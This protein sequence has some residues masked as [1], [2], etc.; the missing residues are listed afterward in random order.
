MT[1]LL[2]N[3]YVCTGENDGFVADG[4][5]LIRETKIVW[6]GRLA[7]LPAQS[8]AVEKRDMGGRIIIPGLVNTHAHGGMSAHR[9]CCDEGNLFEW[10]QALAPHTSI[11]TLED[12]RYGCQLA[13]MEMVRNGITTACDCTRYGAG[14]FASVATSIGMRSLSGALANSPSLR[15]AG[16]PN[17]PLALE[18]TQAALVE[19]A[20]NGLARFYLGAHSPYSCTPELLV[21][22][23]Q[24]ANPL[25]LP[26]VIHVAESAIEVEM[27]R[28]RHGTT[29]FRHLYQLGVIDDRSILAHCVW[30]DD[31]EI[32]LL[33]ESGAGVAHNPISNAKL[34]SGIAPVPAMRRAGIPVGLGTDSTVSNNS[35]D[36]FQEMKFSVLLQRASTLDAH[37]SGAP[38]AFAMA[39]SE[40]ARVLGWADQ[41][42]TLAPGKEA[43]LVVLD[44]DHPLGRTPERILSDLVYR[45]G[46]SHVHDVMVAGKV[47][48]SAGQFTNIDEVETMDQIHRHFAHT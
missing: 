42:G 34:A 26:Y 15:K 2:H 46:P 17:W 41:I 32:T 28:E 6:I 3:A 1:I 44:L 40:G 47:I 43:D 12:N 21:E 7:D 13:V 27:I 22:V 35:L 29:P 20:G 36:I 31:E 39:T 10:A 38:D 8:S 19:H 9:G 14:I 25:G 11:L 5:I 16:R 45:A 37:I 48:F 30:L 18:E 4:A 33:A 24:A 23:K